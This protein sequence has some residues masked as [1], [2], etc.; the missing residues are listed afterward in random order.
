MKKT[1]RV[2]WLFV[3]Y[4]RGKLSRGFTNIFLESEVRFRQNVEIIQ[5]N[6]EHQ[7]EEVAPFA[8]FLRWP[9]PIFWSPII[10]R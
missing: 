6:F 4:Y 7:S 9:L 1:F 8:R 5:E 3:V 10:K 2:T